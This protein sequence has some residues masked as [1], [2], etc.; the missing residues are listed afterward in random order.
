MRRS[1]RFATAVALTAAVA[2]W[3][4]GEAMA[5]QPATWNFAQAAV[6]AAQPLGDYGR[7]V[8]VAVVDTWVDFHDTQFGGRVVDEA[9]CLGSNGTAASCRDHTYAPDACTHGTHVAGTVA[10][11]SYGVA[12]EADVLA[13]QVLSY[14]QANGTC[15][16][17]TTDV[18]AGI[19]FAV[20]KGAQ[21]I[22]LSLGDLVPLLF[23]SSQITHAI[24][25]AA[26][27]GAV[28]VVAAGNN[29]L[30][31]TDSYGANA[32][33]V[34]ATGPS[35]QIASYSDTFTLPEGAVG[36][37]APGGDT[38]SAPSCSASDC[39]LSTLP[40]NQVGLMEGTSMA[41]PHVSGT[42]ALLIAQDPARGRANVV[43]TLA[44]TARP[45]AGAGDGLLDAAAAL[46]ATAPPPEPVPPVRAGSAT[47]AASGSA[48]RPAPAAVPTTAPEAGGRPTAPQ[49]STGSAAAATTVPVTR[50]A[51]TGA[52]ASSTPV[53][54]TGPAAGGRRPYALKS[55]ASA[56]PGWATRHGPV[57]AA[58]A[59]LLGSVAA[60]GGLLVVG[61]GRRRLKSSRDRKAAR[62]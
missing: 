44:S 40:G 3:S 2:C 28:V 22:N 14:D 54:G 37:A 31:F 4:P 29:G 52:A 61:G 36:M 46:R 60:A 57:L 23:Q 32:I 21:V 35:G 41:T 16:G 11:A 6:P 9:D 45:L 8:L 1:V 56:T 5:A 51:P 7:G 43:Q 42:A 13:V 62:G 17:S 26:A 33:M 25:S 34:A 58:A 38:G 55:A 48:S 19:A 10:S 24:D 20:A 39:V 15:S 12:P 30:P 49:A 18:A 59:A 47:P 50:S 27:A 53:P